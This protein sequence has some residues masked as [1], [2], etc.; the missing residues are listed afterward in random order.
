[1]S[2]ASPKKSDSDIERQEKSLEAAS[3]Q[4]EESAQK[5]QFLN[6]S[7][8]KTGVVGT[9]ESNVLSFYRSYTYNWTLAGLPKDYLKDASKYR[10]GELDLVILKSGG[11]GYQGVTP[12]TELSSAQSAAVSDTVLANDPTVGSGVTENNIK[13]V[14]KLKT[15]NNA[16]ISGFNK[17][18]PGRFDMYIENVYVES[19]MVA[20]EEGNMSKPT[21]ITFDVI[22]PY[23]I[24]GFLEALHVTAV[25][26][27]YTTYQNTPFLLKLEFVGYPDDMDLPEPEPI[28]NSVRY[29][30]IVITKAGVEVTERGTR[31]KIQAIP[32]NDRAYGEPNRLKK[33]IKMA[34]T[35]VKEI[36]KD[37]M[38][39]LT[40]QVASVSPDVDPNGL[41]TNNFEPTDIYDIKFPSRDATLGFVDNPENEIAGS[42]LVEIAKDNNL[43]KMVQPEESNKKNGYKGNKSASSSSIKYNP[44]K[45]VVQF[46]EG[47]MVDSLIT[48][49]IRDSAYVKKLLTQVKEKIDDYGMMDYFSV[50]L[51]VENLE[52]ISPITKEP[53]K[54]YTYVVTPYK[55]H[56]SRIQPFGSLPYKEKKLKKLSRR[57]YNYLYTGLNTEVLNFKLDF[58]YLFFEAVPPAMGNKESPSSKGTASKSGD[59]NVQVQGTPVNE[60]KEHTVPLPAVRATSVDVQS[61]GGNALQP[62]HD[63]YSN[64]ARAMHEAIINSKSALLKGEIEIV[65]DP[66]YLVTGGMGNYNPNLKNENETKDGEAAYQFS[67]VLI[68]INFR[69]PVDINADT[70]MMQFDENRIP[71][72][73]V[74]RVIKA[75]SSFKDGF[76]KQVLE[77]MRFNGQVLDQKVPITDPD[78]LLI[79][80]PNPSAQPVPDTSTAE[81]T[82][83]RVSSET[84]AETLGRGAPSPGEPGEPSNFTGAVGG[85][86][87]AEPSLLVQTPGTAPASF[88]MNA[89]NNP[90]SI[91]PTPVPIVSQVIGQ[92]L[93]TSDIASNMR[94]K[95]SGLF[96]LNKTSL[97]SAALV[98]AAANVVTGNIPLKRAA[99]VVA[100]GLLGSVISSALS[101]SNQG[102]GIGIDA[103]VKLTQDFVPSELLTS[104]EAKQGLNINNFSN[105][106]GSLT[107]VVDSVKNIGS[108]AIDNVVSLGAGASR[109][110]GG[111][112]EKLQGLTAP[113]TDPFNIAARGGLDAAKLSGLSNYTGKVNSQISDLMKNT[114]PNLDLEKAANQGIILDYLPSTK[115]ANLPPIPPNYTA[116]EPGESYNG[117]YDPYYSEGNISASTP[118][119]STV[120]ADRFNSARE[121]LSGLTGFPNIADQNIQGAVS[122]KF[123]SLTSGQSPLD[124]LIRKTS[125]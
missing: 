125:I 120:S 73:G 102:T 89:I 108:A 33:P 68:T 42:L 71:F 50:N 11:K 6:T 4:A 2:T 7:T 27:G 51:Q 28:P 48:A 15:D 59:S 43:F 61:T 103:P 46:P 78:D 49:V 21:K 60:Q 91:I 36:L 57:E 80:K 99:G 12:P 113:T 72:S 18:S 84:V 5:T 81:N 47:G 116:P 70:G 123:G 104:N 55:V 65:G 121:S 90:A 17:N 110:I 29:Y 96:D 79:S 56:I 31:Y 100:G 39:N 122:Q 53:Y 111:V 117:G 13:N 98:A 62:R 75:K 69:N 82:S 76:F 119:D 8:D 94:L 118:I 44:G 9:Q 19:I 105:P 10:A 95:T 109:L 41:L 38:D 22:E 97:G 45:T 87:G 58:N 88:V 37:F 66:F 26:A 114:P 34:G 40:K 74:Y 92:P 14:E 63:P 32:V 30:P 3:T 83:Q 1:M 25:A 16:L 24:N 86:G 64:M 67:E 115:I 52:K 77:V 101:K 93:P 85:L 23:S 112:G 124:K 54:K 35:T 107:D 106:V 20:N